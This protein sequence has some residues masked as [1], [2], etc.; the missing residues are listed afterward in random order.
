MNKQGKQVEGMR[1]FLEVRMLLQVV[2]YEHLSLDLGTTFMNFT[3]HGIYLLMIKAIK[4]LEGDK[5]MA[6]IPFLQAHEIIYF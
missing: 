5:Y 3:I 4:I 1:L 2:K 6:T